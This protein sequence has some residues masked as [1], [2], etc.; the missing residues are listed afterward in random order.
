[1][2]RLIKT[3]VCQ[4]F[5]VYLMK[6]HGA[7][8]GSSTWVL[9]SMMRNT[10]R[11]EIINMNSVALLGITCEV[12]LPKHCERNMKVDFRDEKLR[13]GP[14]NT[15]QSWVPL[16]NLDS[17]L[18]A[19]RFQWFRA[20]CSHHGRPGSNCYAI[21]AGWTTD[22]RG[23]WNGDVHGQGLIL[24]SLSIEVIMA[25]WNNCKRDILSILFPAVLYFVIS[26]HFN[27]RYR[28]PRKLMRRIKLA[29]ICQLCP[30]GRN[31]RWVKYQKQLKMSMVYFLFFVK[32]WLYQL[33]FNVFL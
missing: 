15:E 12:G 10:Y 8:G 11:Q 1:M 16:Q 27:R 19:C 31:Y 4:R 3:R 21:E 22:W 17:V 25:K 23:P 24:C 32:E 26:V 2:L 6:R 33:L 18:F 7:A 13:V 5:Q 14:T 29:K 30:R 20:R 28:S 9:M